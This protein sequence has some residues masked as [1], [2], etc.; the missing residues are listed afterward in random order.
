MFSLLFCVSFLPAFVRKTLCLPNILIQTYILG[1]KAGSHALEVLH[2][3]IAGYCTYGY[4]FNWTQRFGVAVTLLICIS[5]VL[6]SNLGR[7]INYTD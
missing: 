7:D 1:T 6:A 2:I 5:E 3:D 4:Y